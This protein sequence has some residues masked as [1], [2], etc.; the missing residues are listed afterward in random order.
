MLW[1]CSGVEVGKET[2][3]KN[4]RVRTWVNFLVTQVLFLLFLIALCRDAFFVFLL[5][6]RL[7]VV[8]V[9]SS[10]GNLLAYVAAFL[11]KGR[12][13]AAQGPVAQMRGQGIPNLLVVGSNLP[14]QSF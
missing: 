11:L 7:S 9:A 13:V 4:K 1:H 6:F 10:A 2:C 8:F 5:V 12:H 14:L 3:K